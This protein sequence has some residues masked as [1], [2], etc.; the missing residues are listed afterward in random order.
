VSEIGLVL[1]TDALLRY[2]EGSARVGGVIAEA[3]DT[4]LTVLIPATCLAAAYQGVPPSRVDYLDIA[5][6][7]PHVV[8]SPLDQ[9][10]CPFIGGWAR[11]LGLDLAHAAVEAASHPL[12]P[13]MTAHRDR[14]TQY[15]PKEWPILDV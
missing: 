13:L 15:L 6:A 12:T 9:D 5:A 7:L 1:D 14:V 8:V 3:A 2:A 4:G 11:T 10:A